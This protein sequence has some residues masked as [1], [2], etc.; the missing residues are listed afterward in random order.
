MKVMCWHFPQYHV[1]S[2]D[3]ELTATK[4]LSDV[5]NLYAKTERFWHFNTYTFNTL[6]DHQ[7]L[8]VA[9]TYR[10]VCRE[11]SDCSR[12]FR[13][14]YSTTTDISRSTSRRAILQLYTN[15]HRLWINIVIHYTIYSR[16]MVPILGHHNS[17]YTSPSPV[18]SLPTLFSHPYYLAFPPS[19]I[20]AP[21]EP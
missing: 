19:L 6:K 7:F 21:S 10:D 13:V 14:V 4:L 5:T 9:F 11:L 3:Y 15:C 18:D 12:Y 2:L 20:H 17:S 16:P 1:F 8:R